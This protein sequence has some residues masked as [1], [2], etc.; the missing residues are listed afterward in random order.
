MR[1]TERKTWRGFDLMRRP[2]S[3]SGTPPSSS[4]PSPYRV[5]GRT[6]CGPPSEAE[7]RRRTLV[8]LRLQPGD[9]ARHGAAVSAGGKA[10]GIITSGTHSFFL[11]YPIALAMVEARSLQVGDSATVDVRGR[12]ARAEVVKLP[13]YRGSA[14]SLSEKKE[15][16]HA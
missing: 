11:G 9:I 12:E 5:R 4:A 14:H 1:P 2:M 6:S 10:L 7:G 16:R 3:R 13:F 8:G 15:S